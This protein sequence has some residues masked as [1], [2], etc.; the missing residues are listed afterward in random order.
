MA[1][2]WI[3]LA[4]VKSETSYRRYRVSIRGMELGCSCPAWTRKTPRQHCKHIKAL[5]TYADNGFE[6]MPVKWSKQGEIWARAQGKIETVA[7]RRQ[8]ER[9]EAKIVEARRAKLVEL[10]KESEE[11]ERKKRVNRKIKDGK[12]VTAGEISGKE[13]W[14]VDEDDD[15]GVRFSLL[16]LY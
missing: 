15:A 6:T 5:F 8:R 12:P 2:G 16:E 11:R 13:N 7:D 1:P 9:K 10:A 14:E 4:E 3:L